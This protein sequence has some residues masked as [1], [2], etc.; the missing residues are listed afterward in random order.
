MLHI[1]PTL[2]VRSVCERFFGLAVAAIIQPT[3]QEI[4]LQN[5]LRFVALDHFTLACD[6][7]VRANN[8]QLV[9]DAAVNAWN[10]SM[11]LID[12][13]EVRDRLYPI[14]RQI[15]DDLIK[16]KGAATVA[17]VD[18]L[19]Q[20]FYL[21]MIEGFANIFNWDGA[22]KTVMEA[23]SFVSSGLQKPLWQWRVITLSKK[24]KNVLDGIQKLKEG[25]PSLQAQVFGILA[26]ASSIPQQ[27][28]ESYM[29]AIEVK[30][31]PLFFVPSHCIS[32]THIVLYFW[33]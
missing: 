26:R 16:C 6:N 30:P 22:L 25:D 5:D 7:G 12:N 17:A 18:K 14:Q 27:Q 13:P 4:S 10:I 2:F 32:Q 1:C 33:N 11:P 29:K 3:G 8:E 9:I 15:I 28:L 24:G 21:A 19:R 23:F 20:Q 31:I